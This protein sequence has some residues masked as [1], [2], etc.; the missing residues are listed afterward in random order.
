M[1]PPRTGFGT[2]NR[3]R[4]R[5]GGLGGSYALARK[6]PEILPRMPKSRRK[7]QHQ[8]PAA[9]FAQRVMA[10]TPLFWWSARQRLGGAARAGAYLREDRERGHCE[11]RREEAADA[12]ALQCVSARCVDERGRHR[13]GSLLAH[14]SRTRRRLRVSARLQPR[15]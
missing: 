2:G 6:T 3:E 8:R 15:L 5:R 11:E 9:R 4:M 14:G 7:A 12:V 13:P 10:I 1:T